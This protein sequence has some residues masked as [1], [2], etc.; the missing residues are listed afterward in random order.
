MDASQYYVTPG[1]IDIHTHFDSQGAD[2]NLQAD[3]NA[4]PN[5]VTTAV[6]AGV[7]K[8]IEPAKTR[9]LAFVEPDR[10]QANKQQV[11]G[12]LAD[13]RNL[14]RAIKSAEA[15]HKIIM[16]EGYDVKR[17]R[18]GDIQTHMYS[19]ATPFVP[20]MR[21]ARARGI[22]F[23]V[24]GFWFRIAAPAISEGFLP[25]TIS[26]DIDAESILLPRADMMTT[27]SKFI[28]LGMTPEQAIERVTMNAARAIRRPELGALSEGAVADIAVVEL[29][30]G[31]FGFLD[32]GHGRLSG[33]RRLRASLRF[34]TARSSGI[35]TG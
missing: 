2:L 16:F 31:Q 21:E 26:T 35:A 19:R 13:D 10:A 32:S 22:L 27:L 33:N 8:G 34:E 17:L 14:D 6:L 30:D 29:E 18:P 7:G 28:N 3:H 20:W 24:G 5:G 4:L 1:L 12:I 15:A 11:V 23:D 25:D 9:L